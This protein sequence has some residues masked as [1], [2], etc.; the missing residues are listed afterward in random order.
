MLLLGGAYLTI[1]SCAMSFPA[2]VGSEVGVVALGAVG[3]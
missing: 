3:A 2:S 1:G